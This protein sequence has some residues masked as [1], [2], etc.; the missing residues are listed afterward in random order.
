MKYPLY[1]VLVLASACGDNHEIAPDA[2]P[3]AQTIAISGTASQRSTNDSIPVEGVTVVA[4]ANTDESTPLA[5]TTTDADG[6][7]T[8]TIDT[9]GVAVEGYLKATMSGMVDT[10]W[11]PAGPI[12]TNY[13][14]AG[15]NMLAPGT[16]DLLA[17]T[18]CRGNQDTAMGVIALEVADASRT[19]IQGAT[20][21]SDPAATSYCYDSG[22]FPNA[23]ATATDPDG[24]AYLFNLT[25]DVTV[26]A[27]STGTTFKPT[28]VKA[29]AGAL[30]TTLI[31]P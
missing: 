30:T 8:L 25:G 28:T 1:L 17:N 21:E 29:R 12:T 31:Q 23:T 11:Y 20:V 19:P 4:F 26:T 9:H 3:A 7:Y 13:A 24:I 18:L 10:Y 2:P 15:L 5:M 6:N 16:L 14:D 27:S 22:A